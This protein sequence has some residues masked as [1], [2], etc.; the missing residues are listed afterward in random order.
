PAAPT[1]RRADSARQRM[2]E[3]GMRRILLWWAGTVTRGCGTESAW[4]TRDILRTKP[5]CSLLSH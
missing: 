1:D 3:I 5:I 4:A 2:A